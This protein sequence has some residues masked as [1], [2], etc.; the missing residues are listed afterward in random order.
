LLYLAVALAGVSSPALLFAASDQVLRA[1]Y[2][3]KVLDGEIA[4]EKSVM[5]PAIQQALENYH[6]LLKQRQLTPAEQQNYAD[7]QKLA[8][9]DEP[10]FRRHLQDVRAHLGAY[11]LTNSKI[12]PGALSSGDHQAINDAL[13]D[14]AAIGVAMKR[15]E[16][17]FGGCQTEMS[18]G[19]AAFCLQACARECATDPDCGQ[20]CE[21]RCGAPTCARTL[22]CINPTF[23]PY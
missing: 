8:S 13:V 4:F 6:N 1:A 15:G 3:A 10:S 9:V 11:L 2:C 22:G 5:P 21:A 12:L 16:T 17:D 7:F 20:R 19:S 23:L 14:A 18:I